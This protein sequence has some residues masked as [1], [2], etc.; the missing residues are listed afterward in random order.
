MKL[1]AFFALMLI[2]ACSSQ[3]TDKKITTS[4]LPTETSPDLIKIAEFHGAQVTGVT[5]DETGRIFANFPRWR[6]NI[7]FSV[8]EIGKDGNPTP[9]PDKEWNTWNGRPR[10]NHFTCVQSVLAHKRS[11]Y[12][13]DPSN[14]KMEGVVGEPKLYEFNLETNEL[15]KTY[16][17]NRTVAPKKSYLNDLRVDDTN[18]KIYI[19]DSGMGGIIVLDIDSGKAK[20]VL[21]K[22]I[23]TKAENVTLFVD[24][25]PFLMKGTPPKIHSDGIA[26]SRDN[27]YLY[28]H[29]LTSYQ[30]YRIPTA[31]L[32]GSFSPQEMETKV[33]NSG[34]TP[35]PDGMI[36]DRQGNLYM[37]D[38]ERNAVA[39]RTPEGKMKILI[40]DERIHW[41][42][43]FT[44]DQDNNL[45]F[46]DSL[47]GRVPAGTPADQTTFSIYKVSLPATV[48]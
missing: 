33:E 31:V 2:S 21:D 42:D 20:R 34:L 11:L 43:T 13:L 24:G 37:A 6:E 8:V 22:H 35:A 46:T 12:V 7:P 1:I 38:L 48:E 26:L 44:I 3:V 36:F 41:P 15:V 32:S 14:P 39:Y 5:S 4:P 40:Q 30:L 10:K 16:T 27:S 29:A 17:F 47:L 19:T 25:K 9:Y 45:I 28:Y 23:S 18:R